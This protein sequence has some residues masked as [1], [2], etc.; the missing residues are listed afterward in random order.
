LSLHSIASARRFSPMRR[1]T[2]HKDKN[3]ASS[4]PLNPQPSLSLG[5]ITDV[6]IAL[7]SE[8]LLVQCHSTFRRRASRLRAMDEDYAE[9]KVGRRDEASKLRKEVG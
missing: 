6:T 3:K 7:G 5:Y 9:S 1:K 2:T 4:S 8:R